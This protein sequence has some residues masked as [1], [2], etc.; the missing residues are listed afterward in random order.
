MCDM[1]I[2]IRGVYSE[3]TEIHVYQTQPNVELVHGP[4]K[5]RSGW[6]PL[7]GPETGAFV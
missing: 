3:K 2:K 4:F 5:E 1:E 7:W 6:A